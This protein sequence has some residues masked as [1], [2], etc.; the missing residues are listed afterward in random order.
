MPSLTSFPPSTLQPPS[1][2][3]FFAASASAACGARYSSTTASPKTFSSIV[4]GLVESRPMSNSEWIW[5]V[6]SAA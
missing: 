2:S 4:V 6:S 1:E 5:S 3:H